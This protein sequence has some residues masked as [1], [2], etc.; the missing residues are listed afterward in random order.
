LTVGHHVAKRL[1]ERWLEVVDEKVALVFVQPAMMELG[2]KSQEEVDEE[3]R[4]TVVE[5]KERGAWDNAGAG[6]GGWDTGVGGGGGEKVVSG[7]GR[8]RRKSPRMS[9][10]GV[11]GLS[12]FS[13]TLNQALVIGIV[14][15]QR[16]GMIVTDFEMETWGLWYSRVCGDVAFSAE[17][18]PEIE[19]NIVDIEGKLRKSLRR[20]FKIDARV[21]EISFCE[22][23]SKLLISGLNQYLGNIL[24]LSFFRS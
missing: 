2:I 14:G 19:V 12:R 18:T 23:S 4:E 8:R 21:V 15:V 16:W 7:V 10:D 5:K 11:M 17:S 22:E 9:L 24:T 3:G 20:V 6:A 1:V 13:R